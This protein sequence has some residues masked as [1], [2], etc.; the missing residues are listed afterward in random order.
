MTT[1]TVRLSQRYAAE[2]ATHLA[3]LALTLIQNPSLATDPKVQQLRSTMLSV[4]D[5]VHLEC[6]AHDIIDYLYS[7]Y[8]V[9]ETNN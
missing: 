6:E 5:N 2:H 7:I 8:T 1:R 9:V 3:A 4:T